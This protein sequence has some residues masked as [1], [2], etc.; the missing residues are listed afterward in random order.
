[1]VHIKSVLAETQEII[2]QYA[3]AKEMQIA[4]FPLDPRVDSYVTNNFLQGTL[5]RLI[6]FDDGS[7]RFRLLKADS[8]G[9]LIVSQTVSVAF[10]AQ[11]AGVATALQG[12]SL[13]ALRV[14]NFGRTFDNFDVFI[15]EPHPSL[16]LLSGIGIDVGGYADLSVN[17]S[18]TNACT[19]TI[20]VSDDNV[21]FYEIKSAADADL[22]WLCSNE[23]INFSVPNFSRFIRI[24]VKNDTATAGTT[25]VVLNAKA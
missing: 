14:D 4:D 21:N 17:V 6:G 20:Q 25:T 23:K 22:S 12:N 15:S 8:S 1:M 18:T 24:L 9:R 10:A 13:G 5:A 16:G 3:M 7:K 11:V 19:V 2:K